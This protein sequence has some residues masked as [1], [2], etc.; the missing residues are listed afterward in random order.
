MSEC[1]MLEDE[2][3]RPWVGTAASLPCLFL[4]AW[5]ELEVTAAGGSPSCGGEAQSHWGPQLLVYTSAKE[6]QDLVTR[7]LR[8]EMLNQQLH[9]QKVY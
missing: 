4:T 5:S 9:L 7:K 1:S 6:L 8:V 3:S 2:G